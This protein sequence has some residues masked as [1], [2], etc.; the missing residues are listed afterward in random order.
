MHFLGYFF[1]EKFA[2]RAYDL[3]AKTY[4]R[5]KATPNFPK[6]DGIDAN[7]FEG[8][9]SEKENAIELL[10]GR[11]AA[12]GDRLSHWQRQKKSSSFRGVS[13]QGHKW[14]AQ[15]SIHSQMCF[16]GYF[17][18]E[19]DAAKAYDEAARMCRG[20]NAVYNFTPDGK[21]TAKPA[22]TVTRPTDRG[23]LSASA[24]ASVSKLKFSRQKR[25]QAALPM[26]T[27]GSV[28][29]P[30]RAIA[31]VDHRHGHRHMTTAEQC[32]QLDRR[33]ARNNAPVVPI[34]KGC[35]VVDNRTAAAA[36]IQMP[37]KIK[38]ERRVGG[39]GSSAEMEVAMLMATNFEPGAPVRARVASATV[40]QVK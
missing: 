40:C 4:R 5:N 37:I 39:S 30:A 33:N 2:A 21:P 16:L 25:A 26:M 19:E 23:V 18:Q 15:I 13:W 24:L 14:K 11:V 8:P 20:A 10:Q 31:V 28:L 7:P 6:E 34:V 9:G 32:E 1:D 36:M 29:H 27:L 12:I 38:D 35:H 17:K 3:A 22:A